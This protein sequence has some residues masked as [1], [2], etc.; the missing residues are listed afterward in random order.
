MQLEIN[1]VLNVTQVN[2]GPGAMCHIKGRFIDLIVY[3]LGMECALGS[4]A[5]FTKQETR[6]RRAGGVV[7]CLGER[8]GSM[9]LM[10]HVALIPQFFRHL[11]VA[12]VSF[13][14]FLSLS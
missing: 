9:N 7:T 5:D 10:N 14:P 3:F 2:K 8:K 11:S 6:E 4:M 13:L 12:L 1:I